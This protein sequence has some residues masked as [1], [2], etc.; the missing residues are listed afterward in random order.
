VWFDDAGKEQTQPIDPA[1]YVLTAK[2]IVAAAKQGEFGAAINRELAQ[3]AP[4]DAQLS[5]FEELV[6]TLSPTDRKL[7]LAYTN[8][9]CWGRNG[10]RLAA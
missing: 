7:W 4:R 2:Q 1:A 8:G 10:G 5:E 3:L 9:F 6:S